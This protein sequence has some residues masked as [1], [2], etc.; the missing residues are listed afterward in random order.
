ML[1]FLALQ[2]SKINWAKAAVEAR[3]AKAAMATS[4]QAS[5]NELPPSGA[6]SPMAAGAPSTSGTSSSGVT[7]T[8]GT[9][10]MIFLFVIWESAVAACPAPMF[11]T[12]LRASMTP[13]CCSLE[14]RAMPAPSQ[15]CTNARATGPF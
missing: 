15:A 13:S 2:L 14:D 4:S 10:I 12:S 7:V 5:M 1:D 6:T 11:A 8:C 9:L 3:T